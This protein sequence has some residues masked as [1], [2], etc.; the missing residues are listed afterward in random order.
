[1]GKWTGQ[2]RPS[3]HSARSSIRTV[4]PPE[5]AAAQTGAAEMVKQGASYLVEVAGPTPA[6][7]EDKPAS[8]PVYRAAI[9]KD[10]PPAIPYQ[11]LYEMFQASVQK[12]PD[13]NCLGRREG[14]GYSWLTYKQTSE[15][16]ADIGCALVKVGLQPHGRVGVYGANS[17]EWM[18]AMQACNRQNLYCVPLYDSL[19][20]HAIEYIVNHSESTC[21]FTQSEKF[22]TLAKSLPHVNDLV[23]TVVYWGKGDAAAAEAAKAAGAAVYSF[24]EFLQLGKDNAA[25]PSPPKPEDLCTIMYTSGTT[26]DPKGV[27]L[28]HENVMAAIISLQNFVAKYNIGLDDTDVFLS[29]LPLAHIFDRT[30]EELYLHLGASIG[31]WRG[32]IKGLMEDTGALRPTMFCGVPR[33]FDRIYAGVMQKVSEGSFVKKALFNWGYQRKLHFLNKGL[34]YDKAAP[35]FDKIV[36]SKIKEK[37]GGRV[38]LV[39]SGGAPL[40]RHVEDFLKVTMC[41]RVVQGYGLT[42]T[43]A[44]S[45]IAVPDEPAHAGTVGPPQP[46]LEFKLEAVPSMNYDPMA[47]PPR[48]EVVVRGSSVFAG[49]Y[50]AQDKTDEVL[51]K[52]GWFHTGDIG[53]ITPTGALRIIDRMKNIFKLSQGE[54]IA[55]EKVEG[56]YKMNSA[57]EQIWVY[58]NS[59]ESQLV[60]VVVPVASK[61]RAIAAQVG[62]KNTDVEQDCRDE[63]VKKE[64]LA[65]LT[66]TGKEGKLKG[67]EM[68]RAIYIESPSNLFSVENDLLTPTFKLK[69]APLQKRYQA[70]I[71]AM[72]AALKKA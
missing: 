6:N 37:L 18:I 56:I 47:D 49:Y 51:E 70:E 43:C 30:A 16:V 21:V 33:V 36:F 67:F 13:N 69:R 57:V 11:S 12:F 17:P 58:G 10:G 44:A 15:Q 32:D 25:P 7:G 22:S 71:D 53:E 61:L 52:D 4:R 39:V 65:Q 41:C 55:V 28:T 24:E 14:A 20:E 1:M 54:Y 8:G 64:L 50:K 29:F 45:F 5:K 34:T 2:L 59:Y 68:V 66:A 27:Q 19:G 46:V 60:A 72:Y 48:G 31:Y 38:K 40:A 35:L 23:K 62:S 9:A 26:G 3:V 42:E 63:K